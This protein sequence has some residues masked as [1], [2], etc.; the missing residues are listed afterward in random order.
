MIGSSSN[1]MRSSVSV[2]ASMSTF[3]LIPLEKLSFSTT[4]S[5]MTNVFP[6]VGV[7]SSPVSVVND[8]A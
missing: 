8:L 3:V 2:Q 1:V 5:T 4:T 6:T 7:T